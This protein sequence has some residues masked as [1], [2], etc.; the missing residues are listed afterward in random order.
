MDI[1]SHDVRK[2]F[3]LL[4]KKTATCWSSFIVS[5]APTTWEF[6]A[7]TDGGRGKWRSGAKAQAA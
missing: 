4:L 3:R 6:C 5:G 1:V 2:F 7:E